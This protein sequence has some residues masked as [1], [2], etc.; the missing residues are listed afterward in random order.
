M[1]KVAVPSEDVFSTTHSGQP[2][3][4]ILA[5]LAARHPGAACHFVE[6]KLSTLE[7][8]RA[9]LRC[10]GWHGCSLWGCHPLLLQLLAGAC[11]QV[12]KVPELRGWALYLVDWG[13]NTAEERAR[14][15]A[16][17]RIE[18][19]GKARLTQLVGL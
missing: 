12:C 13:Y 8:A 19:V 1:A 15:A 7:K 6:D 14:A 4:E 11:A 17:P 5:Q 2:K 16:N 18:V 3:S 9:R 10:P